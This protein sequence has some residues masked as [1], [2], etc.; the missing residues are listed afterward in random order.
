MCKDQEPA[1]LLQCPARGR[2]NYPRNN[3]IWDW[4][5]WPSDFISLTWF[6]WLPEETQATDISTDPSRRR[7]M[8]PDMALSSSLGLNDIL[9][10]GRNT[11]Y[12]DQDSSGCGMA[13]DTNEATG[14]SPAPNLWWQHG[15]QTSTKTPTVVGP[16]T[17]TWSLAAAESVCHHCHRWQFRPLRTA[18]P[19][20]QCGPQTLTWPQTSGIHM[21]FCGNR[22][23][24]IK[25]DPG[26]SMATDPD[27]APSYSS[28]PKVTMVLCSSAGYSDLH[29]PGC[30]LPSATNMDPGD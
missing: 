22:Y 12:S 23:L 3:E 7:I 2:A 17:Q 30:S 18:W 24:N 5:V 13:P 28:G 20:W 6:L 15:T 8:D 10:L 9:A 21:T 11:D 1:L 27:M 16:R 25:T 26:C 14:C 29:V 19:Q 4:L